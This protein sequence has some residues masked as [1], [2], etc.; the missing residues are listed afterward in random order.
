MAAQGASMHPPALWLRE[1]GQA[2]SPLRSQRVT[3]RAEGSNV[4][5]G[6]APGGSQQG[7]GYYGRGARAGFLTSVISE[8]QSVTFTRVNISLLLHHFKRSPLNFTVA[9]T[10][11]Y[12]QCRGTG[13]A[14]SL[15]GLH[16]FPLLPIRILAPSNC[17]SIETR[18]LGCER[19]PRSN[20]ELS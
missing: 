18:S 3:V 15:K 5:V 16:R 4:A 20:C 14:A 1:L 13:W 8:E 10:K 17:R 19:A 12:L 7:V 11:R 6:P 2:A 9:L